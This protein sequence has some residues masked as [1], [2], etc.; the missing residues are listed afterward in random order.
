MVA[1]DDYGPSNDLPEVLNGHSDR[2]EIR[3]AGGTPHPVLAHHADELADYHSLLDDAAR[4]GP[5][6]FCKHCNEGFA[7]RR[8]ASAAPRLQSRKFC[9]HRRRYKSIARSSSPPIWLYLLLRQLYDIDG[10]RLPSLSIPRLAG[11]LGDHGSSWIEYRYFACVF[12]SLGNHL[13]HQEIWPVKPKGR[14]S[15]I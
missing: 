13:V 7:Q 14:R 9:G 12:C 1:L 5:R 15:E 2:E 8:G 10:S 4:G 6:H 11:E 3:M